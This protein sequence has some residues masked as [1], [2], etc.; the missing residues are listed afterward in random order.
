MELRRPNHPGFTLIEL[1]LVLVVISAALGIAAPSLS[2]WGR[3]Q[4][5]RDAGDEFLATVRWARA[6]AIANSRTYR[7]N[8]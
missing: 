3:G 7:L 6:Q 2:H 5:L 1:L 4:R 8:V